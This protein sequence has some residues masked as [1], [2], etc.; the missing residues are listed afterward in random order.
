MSSSIKN[1]PFSFLFIPLLLIGCATSKVDKEAPLKFRF[2][3]EYI[4]PKN[5]N[6]DGTKVGGLSDLDYDGT[7]FYAVC[8]LPS[9]PRI[10]TFSIEISGQKI[11]TVQ[12]EKVI[13]IKKKS[14]QDQ[15]LVFDSEGLAYLSQK[16]QFILS[17]EGSISRKKDPF[18]A[19]L[20]RHGKV[21]NTYKIPSYFEAD[22]K[23][24]P[25]NNGVFEGLSR[26]VDKK[27]IWV[28]TELPLK[29]DGRPVKLYKTKSPV[30]FTYFDRNDQKPKKQ[31]AYRLGPLRKVPFLPFGMNGV[32]AILEYAPE[33]F[34]VL[35]RAFSAGH[36]RRGI[37]AM[38]YQVDARNA[39]N[40]LDLEDLHR[41]LG[42]EVIPAKKT[43]VFDFNSI[44]K[45][46]TDKIIDNLEGIS[47]GPKLANGHQSLLVISD[48]NF[49]SF[50]KQMN[51]VI[52]LEIIPK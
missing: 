22:I 30:R 50:T 40:T 31:F 45:Q 5:L 13:K 20:N 34:L 17:S 51:Q 27:G 18:V 25:R 8:D 16:R 4:I 21:L 32:S 3:D 11:D 23:K 19:T 1:K 49:N 7:Y 26:S 9:A 12:F 6:V 10:Y 29:Q 35:E 48:N 28:S 24:G 41:K 15:S 36:G 44:R 38:L 43:L 2:L 52:L 37:R 47:F 33:Q 39:T 46:L 14:D 42:D